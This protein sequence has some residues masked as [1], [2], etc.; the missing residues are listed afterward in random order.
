MSL[1]SDYFL[2]YHGLSLSKYVPVVV[3]EGLEDECFFETSALILSLNRKNFA[4]AAGLNSFTVLCN[5]LIKNTISN[6]QELYRL[7][8]TL[9]KHI[10]LRKSEKNLAHLHKS[11]NYLSY[12]AII[13]KDACEKLIS[14]FDPSMFKSEEDNIT[15][16][17]KQR[18][19]G[20]KVQK[21]EI[22]V[23]LNELKALFHATEDL[24]KIAS[25]LNSQKFSVGITGVMNAGKSTM[26]NALMGKEVLGTSVVPET[27]N[28]SIIRYA[29]K[30]AAKVVYWNRSQWKRIEQSAKEIKS[31]ASFLQET[32]AHFKDGL[33]EYILEESRVDHVEINDLSEYT[34][35]GSE[36]K[37]C[38]LVKQVELGC[39]LNFLH[40][41]IEVVDTP[42]L[43]DVVVQRE[44][45]TKQYIAQCDLMIHLMN[46]SQSATSKDIEFIVDALLYQNVTKVLVVI[47]R[48]DTV[49]EADVQETIDYTKASLIKRLHALNEDTKL[50]LVLKGLDF[51]ALSGKMALLHK[52]GRS[53]EA[54]EAGYSLEK[55][56]ITRVESFLAQTLF[57]KENERSALIIRSAKRRLD[58]AVESELERMHH[59]LASLSKS[60]SELEVEL[61]ALRQ[62]KSQKSKRLENLKEQIIA[63]EGE[64]DVY[65]K[66]QESIMGHE[67]KSLQSVIRQRLLDDVRYC[68]EKEKKTPTPGRIKDIIE[69][70]LRHGL[71][72]VVRDYRHRLR[73]KTDKVEEVL[74]EQYPECF[75]ASTQETHSF[76]NGFDKGFLV[77]NNEVLVSRLI[78]L[79]AKS[80]LKSLLQDDKQIAEVIKEEFIHLEE[81]MKSRALEVSQLLLDGLFTRVNHSVD[82]LLKRLDRDEK[83][84]QACL[85]SIDEDETS[86]THRSLQLHKKAKIIELIAKR[87]QG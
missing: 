75:D 87:Y 41:G 2:L 34:S 1:A 65:L 81:L 80:S 67:L 9:I 39:E 36:S 26:L 28:L 22:L 86:R 57:S 52:T 45:I 66:N 77:S 18:D 44:E 53:Q 72:D 83:S 11:F 24:D 78:T 47:T 55:S 14:L 73:V 71:I 6:P 63:Y 23:A 12:E 35:A 60:E 69:K 79:I 85:L 30:P 25:Y 33:D 37:R 74:F 48:I 4:K 62:K 54:I 68:L 59:E 76:E 20:F 43:D 84:L 3:D 56:G 21:H 42:G 70:S 10:L 31:I 40:E 15:V 61:E 64:L 5:R 7:Q 58:K 27:A 49:S 50:D 13:S 16:V 29:S 32:A 17:Q 8:Q 82:A 19:D 38:N 51:I 46:V